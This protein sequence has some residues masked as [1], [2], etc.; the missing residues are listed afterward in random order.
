MEKTLHYHFITL[1]NKKI[2]K[3]GLA[4]PPLILAATKAAAAASIGLA[5]FC[6]VHG[7]TI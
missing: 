5:D 3:G 4:H 1:L 7:Y 6:F 2:K